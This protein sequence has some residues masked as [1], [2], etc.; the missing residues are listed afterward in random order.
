LRLFHNRDIIVFFIVLLM[1]VSAS[2]AKYITNK[3]TLG[4]QT[5]SVVPEV[6]ELHNGKIAIGTRG[7]FNIYAA[8]SYSYHSEHNHPD[9]LSGYDVQGFVEVDSNEL[10]VATNKAI[11][12]FNP[13]VEKFEKL[14]IDSS[15]QNGLINDIRTLTSDPAGNIWCHTGT[16]QIYCFDAKSRSIIKNVNLKKYY[17]DKIHIQTIAIHNDNLWVS[18][19]TETNFPYDNLLVSLDINNLD[20]IDS[21]ED[22]TFNLSSIVTEE[23]YQSYVINFIIDDY[24]NLWATCYNSTSFVKYKD[25]DIFQKTE[26]EDYLLMIFE[27]WGLKRYHI[28][29]NKLDDIEP[30]FVGLQDNKNKKT[31]FNIVYI[32]SIRTILSTI[33]GIWNYNIITNQANKIS[34]NILSNNHV[35]S[36]AL[37]VDKYGRYW[38]GTRGEGLLMIDPKKQDSIVYSLHSVVNSR[39]ISDD[40]VLSLLESGDSIYVGTSNSINIINSKTLK[41]E[42]FTLSK[43]LEGRQIASMLKVDSLLWIATYQNL[44]NYN[45]NSNLTH[46]YSTNNGTANREYNRYSS[47]LG[48]DGTIFFG[49]VNGL[50]YQSSYKD[51]SMLSPISYFSKMYTNNNPMKLDSNIAYKKV[52]YIDPDVYLL[53][54]DISSIHKWYDIYELQK[55]YMLEGH[56]DHWT[57]FNKRINLV[58]L[59]KGEYKLKVRIKNNWTVLEELEKTIVVS[60]HFKDSPYLTFIIVAIVILIILSFV[61]Y[62]W[63]QK[64]RSE[65]KLIYLIDIKTKELKDMNQELEE[66]NKMKNNIMSILSHDLKSPLAFISSSLDFIIKQFDQQ[67]KKSVLELLNLS[68]NNTQQLSCLQSDIFKWANSMN[69]KYVPAYDTF[70]INY[71]IDTSIKLL[72]CNA[73]IKSIDINNTVADDAIV[74]SDANIIAT[75]IRNLLSNAI[76]YSE[77]NSDIAIWSKTENDTIIIGVTDEGI[78]LAEPVIDNIKNK[79]KVNSKKGTSGEIGTG[80]GLTM[81]IDLLNVLGLT[82]EVDNTKDKGTTFYF[83]LPAKEDNT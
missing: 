16:N 2:E 49:G 19:I 4:M 72:E 12:I 31:F 32:D 83:I 18:L 74:Y 5:Q 47:L 59:P 70:N 37:V 10:W 53:S 58:D 43:S 51:Y 52:L 39:K 3:I 79:Q 61:F 69:N 71:L 36:D 45:F 76:K 9:S 73:S 77:Y 23:V 11:N 64:R 15:Q 67:S 13:V 34:T 82:L 55:E 20:N 28:P 33:N 21:I 8:K 68:F 6:Y 22:I 26:Y 1:I 41:V 40:N 42:K 65:K 80:I 46:A 56:D 66:A 35:F 7:G 24:D 17:G 25:S 81:C 27:Q 62:H 78:G 48:K 38:I 54:F 60:R 30:N 57:P 63:S 75:I 50:T 44:Y 29:T 14:F